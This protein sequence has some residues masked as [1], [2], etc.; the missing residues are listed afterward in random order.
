MRVV[1]TGAS[2]FIGR[3]LMASLANRGVDVL[4]VTR[5]GGADGFPHM[6]VKDYGE[7]PEGDVLVHLAE[8]RDIAKAER[9]NESY[10]SDSSGLLR[11][12]LSKRYMNVIYASSAAIYGDANSYPRRPDEHVEPTGSYARAKL[13]SEKLVLDAGGAC[14]RLSNIY[15]PGMAANNVISDVLKQIP[16]KGPLVVRRASPIRD[17]LWVDDASE[18]IAEM[19]TNDAHGIY[20]M[21]S[22][23][24]VAIGDMARMALKIAGEAERGIVSSDPS[25]KPSTLL[26][27]IS[28]TTAEF[29]WSPRVDLA[30]GLS[31]MIKEQK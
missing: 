11:G 20:N 12:L 5:G 26:L 23:K 8:N 25:N 1:V 3:H 2:G 28:A 16:G 30:A 7:T 17:F 19:V 10:I 29:N 21:G 24:G 22:G 4:A 13:A 27:D 6:T 31:R 14:V 15:G 18:G 9:E